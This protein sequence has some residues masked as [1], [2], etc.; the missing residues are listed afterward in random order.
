MVQLR[1]GLET[2]FS[3]H[4]PNAFNEQKSKTQISFGHIFRHGCLFTMGR[5][6][7]VMCSRILA[8]EMAG[9][10]LVVSVGIMSDQT[11][12]RIMSFDGHSFVDKH[13]KYTIPI[14]CEII[15]HVHVRDTLVL[16]SNLC[17]LW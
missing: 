1:G 12:G 4:V 17:T 13:P 10:S 2:K 8:T 11:S 7:F 3:T 6:R 16:S 14:D 9:G 5:C 15:F